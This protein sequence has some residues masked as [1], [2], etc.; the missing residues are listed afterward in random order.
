MSKKKE[1]IISLVVVAIILVARSG[2]NNFIENRSDLLRN[3]ERDKYS[4]TSISYQ[5]PGEEY[6]T[7]ASN[8]YLINDEF[9]QDNKDKSKEQIEEY[10]KVVKE[11]NEYSRYAIELFEHIKNL[12]TIKNINLDNKKYD[13][14]MIL[15]IQVDK[16]I[17]KESWYYYD[18]IELFEHIKNL[19]TIKNINL[20]NKKYDLS[21][22][23]QIQV[24]K[25]I[26]KESW[27]YYE[28]EYSI[29][30]DKGIIA[31]TNLGLMGNDEGTK[32]KYYYKM[33]KKALDLANRIIEKVNNK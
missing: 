29:Y 25:L 14:S 11:G 26:D 15:Q 22:I 23:L 30:L 8:Y 17:D 6:S 10:V 16:L 28:G 18:A 27:Y 4:Y 9:Y 20:D 5:M 33:D 12:E 24:D 19:E 13:L 21:M 31:F 2:Y 3:Y 1:L 32:K 7:S